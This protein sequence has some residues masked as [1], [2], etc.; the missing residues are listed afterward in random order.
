MKRTRFP[1]LNHVWVSAAIILLALRPLMTPIP[2]H[3][4]WWHMAMGRFIVQNGTIPTT[5]RFSYTKSGEAFYNQGWLSQLLMYGLHSIGGIELLLL[6]Q[7]ATVAFA[8]GL[9]L[10]LSIKR[11]HATRLSVGVLLLAIMPLSFDNW[12]VRPQSYALPIF[13]VFLHILTTWR[14]ALSHTSATDEH[15][16]SNLRNPRLWLL[17]LLMVLWVNVHGSFVLGGALIALIFLGEWG[18]RLVHEYRTHGFA[19]RLLLA[20]ACTLPLRSLFAWGGVTAFAMLINP[21]GIGVLG[22]VF[23][24]LS[25]S[26]VTN[27]VTEWA[28]PTIRDTSG[29][30]FFVFLI[31][32]AIIFAYAPHKPDPLDVMLTLPFLWLALGANRNIIWFGIVAAP[33]LT[34]QIAPWFC[35]EEQDSSSLR[36]TG[37]PLANTILIGM[38]LLLLLAGLPW[39]KPALDLPPEIGTLIAPDTPVEAVEVLKNDLDRPRHLFHAMSY[40]S[41]LIWA[42]P[43]Q[44]VF[45]DPRIELYPFAQWQDYINL[46]RGNNTTQLMEKYAIDG[47]LLNNEEQSRLLKLVY[48]NPAWAVRYEDEYTTYLVRR[49]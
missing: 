1:T 31:I 12:N 49:W 38:L 25:T 19:P 17:P 33:L 22:Y 44:P 39:V 3:D 24:L 42:A 40:G 13:V 9:L 15:S 47:L 48:N 16:E 21:R 36:V 4:F 30:I 2:P 34:V 6:F 11:S 35:Q 28:P 8:Y 37:V 5:D 46:N 43:E 7:A 23:N 10:H 26:S 29:T 20:N 27:L 41:Y 45:A 32:C 18:R 14:L